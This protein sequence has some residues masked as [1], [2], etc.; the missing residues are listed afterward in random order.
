MTID[1]LSPIIPVLYVALQWLALRQMQNQWHMA[2]FAP[3]L[4]MAA[5]LSLFIIGIALN[6]SGATIWLVLGLPAATAYLLFLLP[7]YWLMA[8]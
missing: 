8:R 3:V 2:A 6:S 7:A 4:A 1:T 5:A